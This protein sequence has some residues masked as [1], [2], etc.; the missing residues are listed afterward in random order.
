LADPNV[1]R[2]RALV[3]AEIAG[4]CDPDRV[5]IAV[6]ADGKRGT[7]VAIT[8]PA[9][10]TGQQGAIERV[11]GGYLFDHAVKAAEG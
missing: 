5:D 10:L 7:Q 2:R 1:D 6:E 4:V 11:L 3:A 9:G 8:L